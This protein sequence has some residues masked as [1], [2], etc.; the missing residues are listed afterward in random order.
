MVFRFISPEGRRPEG[1]I[2]AILPEAEPRVI[3]KI[4]NEER[5]IEQDLKPFRGLFE[6]SRA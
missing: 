1:D 6:I 5:D 3:S 2:N 4:S